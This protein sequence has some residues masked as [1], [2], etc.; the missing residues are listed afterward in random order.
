MITTTWAASTLCLS[1]GF[2]QA[3]ISPQQVRDALPAHLAKAVVRELVKTLAATN[4]TNTIY[5]AELLLGVM[6]RPP[7]PLRLV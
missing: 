1:I 2:S 4:A 6:E 7:T 3:D 5:C